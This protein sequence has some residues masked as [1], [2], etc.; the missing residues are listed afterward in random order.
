MPLGA[1]LAAL[2]SSESNSPGYAYCRQGIWEFLQAP[3]YC[4]QGYC[5]RIVC[6]AKIRPNS[7]AAE[8]QLRCRISGVR[9]C[10]VKSKG[11]AQAPET[12]VGALGPWRGCQRTNNMLKLQAQVPAVLSCCGR[13]QRIGSMA[14]SVRTCKDALGPN[15]TSSAASCSKESGSW[16]NGA[17][18]Q[19][20]QWALAA[21]NKMRQV[22]NDVLAPRLHCKVHVAAARRLCR[23]RPPPISHLGLSKWAQDKIFGEPLPQAAYGPIPGPKGAQSRRNAATVRPNWHL[24]SS[25]PRADQVPKTYKHPS[26]RVPHAN[27]LPRTGLEL[28]ALRHVARGLAWNSSPGHENLAGARFKV[29][30]V[31]LSRY[32]TGMLGVCCTRCCKALD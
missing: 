28:C 13:L 24:A 9:F 18:D 21:P 5:R 16:C 10:P 23:H 17:P 26:V 31:K 11:C 30:L 1:A 14:W 4:R 2:E 19:M 32:S 15:T 27:R 6:P 8:I 20:R 29:V 3:G 7:Q 12:V 25:V 22:S